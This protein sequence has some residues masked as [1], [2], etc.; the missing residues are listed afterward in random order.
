MVKSMLVFSFSILMHKFQ[1]YIFCTSRP[2]GH[3]SVAFTRYFQT[4][5][6]LFDSRT[7]IDLLL[8][9]EHNCN[10]KKYAMP[11]TEVSC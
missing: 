3:I 5:K 6:K 7:K 2:Q 8:I 10:G 11:F 1:K 4:K 9:K